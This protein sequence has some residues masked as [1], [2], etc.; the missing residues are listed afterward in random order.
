MASQCNTKQFVEKKLAEWIKDGVI[1]LDLWNQALEG[2]SAEKLTSEESFS[3]TRGIL[4]ARG[5]IQRGNRARRS[6]DGA[7]RLFARGFNSACCAAGC[8]TANKL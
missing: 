4:E 7:F 5:Y 1:V 8:W 3:G 6:C 2:N